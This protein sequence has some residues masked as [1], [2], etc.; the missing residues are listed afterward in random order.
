M[1]WK[2]S[3]SV[4]EINYCCKDFT[5]DMLLLPLYTYADAPTLSNHAADQTQLAQIF[6]CH[7]CDIG[8]RFV[9]IGPSQKASCPITLT[10]F[11][12]GNEPAHFRLNATSLR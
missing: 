4:N 5:T 8:S 6:H 1:E 10:S 9:Q 11:V 12:V 7:V 3:T 2:E